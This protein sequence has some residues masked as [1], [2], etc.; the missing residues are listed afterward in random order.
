M[1]RTFSI[2]LAEPNLM[3]REKIANVLS[4]NERIWCVVQ[5]D[6]T[7]GLARGASRLKPDFILADLSILKEADTL[8]LLRRCSTDSRII[9]LADSQSE[10]YV[11]AARRLG[12]DG[13]IEKG[14]VGEGIREEIS[15]LSADD[16]EGSD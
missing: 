16:G 3:L 13:A 8:S 4:R 6:G 11:S 15:S 9:A 14:R 1:R 5:V 10:P 12:L 2:L 7:E